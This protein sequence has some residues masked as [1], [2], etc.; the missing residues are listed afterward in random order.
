MKSA[1]N[2]LYRAQNTL[3][4][5]EQELAH[6]KQLYCA[7]VKEKQKLSEEAEICRRKM[8]AATTLINGLSGEKM[9]WTMQSKAF[10]EQMT[11]LVGDVLLSTAFLS[12]SGPFNQEFRQT[13]LQVICNLIFPSRFIS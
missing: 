13:L 5:K 8:N 4:Q 7:A 1:N 2:D 9:R 11:R 3:V 10:K 6:V 12:Y